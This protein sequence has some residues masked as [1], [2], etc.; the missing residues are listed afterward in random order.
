MDFMRAL[1]KISIAI[2]TICSRKLKQFEIYCRTQNDILGF[3]NAKSRAVGRA[4][5]SR[6]RG[7]RAVGNCNNNWILYDLPSC[8]LGP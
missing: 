6:G 8:Y 2:F 3:D 5:Y 4:K 1:K 7:L